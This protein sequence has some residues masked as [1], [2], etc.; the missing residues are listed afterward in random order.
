MFSH[1]LITRFNL[2]NPKWG[3]TKNNETLLTDE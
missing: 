1:Y 2:K 3:V